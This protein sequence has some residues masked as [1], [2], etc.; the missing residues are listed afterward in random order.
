MFLFQEDTVHIISHIFCSFVSA[1]Y[2]QSKEQWEWEDKVNEWFGNASPHVWRNGKII[3]FAALNLNIG[4]RGRWQTSLFIPV[5]SFFPMGMCDKAHKTIT[6]QQ[7]HQLSWWFQNMLTLGSLDT[8]PELLKYFCWKQ[9]ELIGVV[10]M[11]HNGCP[12]SL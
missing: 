10:K 12:A 3:T 1:S 7:N 11:L 9:Q 5:V 8:V 4:V 2:R 6:L